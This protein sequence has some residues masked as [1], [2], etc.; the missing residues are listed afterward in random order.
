VIKSQHNNKAEGETVSA[1]HTLINSIWNKEKFP[2]QW[3]E[4]VVVPIDKKGDK[5]VITVVG[6]HCYQYHT[7]VYETSFL[8]V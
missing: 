2:Y 5:T 1:I 6:Y 4:S 3:N 8:Y 7:K